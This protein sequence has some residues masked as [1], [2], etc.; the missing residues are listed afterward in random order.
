[1]GNHIDI[2]HHFIREIVQ[3]GD[4]FTKALDEKHLNKLID[5]GGMLSMV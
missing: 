3:L 1:M 4:I 2:R 5:V